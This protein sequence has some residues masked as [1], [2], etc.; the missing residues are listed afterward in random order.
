MSVEI[1]R[2]KK[3]ALLHE[4]GEYGYIPETYWRRDVTAVKG[5]FK[6]HANTDELTVAVPGDF[7]KLL[8]DCGPSEMQTAIA[9]FM[10]ELDRSGLHNCVLMDIADD[11]LEEL[12][13]EEGVTGDCT[14]DRIIQKDPF[15][16]KV[17]YSWEP[18][19]TTMEKGSNGRVLV[20]FKDF[21][22][23]EILRVYV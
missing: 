6:I 13:C 9:A 23:E 11:E 3:Y 10:G 14:L 21:N 8:K 5:G 20:V 1:V 22:A 7:A 4:R 17:F 18:A 19:K 15:A 2:N 12:R 16:A